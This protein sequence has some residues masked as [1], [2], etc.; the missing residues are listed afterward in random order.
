M[1]THTTLVYASLFC[2]GSAGCYTE[3]TSSTG[4]FGLLT[5]NFSTDYEGGTEELTEL[6][7]MTRVP[8]DIDVDL[9]ERGSKRARGD[10]GL[11]EHTAGPAF[12]SQTGPSYDSDDPRSFEIVAG[13]AMQVA[14]ES[15][16]EGDLF[17]RISLRFDDPSHLDVVTWIREPWEDDWR[18]RP[19][20]N[21]LHVDEG[22]QISFLAIPMAGDVR[23]GGDF[24]PQI[25]VTPEHLVVPDEAVYAVQEEGMTTGGEAVTFYAIEPGVVT[26]TVSEPNHGIEVVRT[27]EI[28]GS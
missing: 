10:G 4:E 20:A 15:H 24:T 14:V 8:H 9:T 5:Y 22:A 25:T 12:V 27:V 2:L 16:L 6:P 17:D 3:V 26:F 7:L 18:D 11:I 21:S 28:S 19:H 13:H 1:K 23:L